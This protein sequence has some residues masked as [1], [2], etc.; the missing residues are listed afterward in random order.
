[1]W[2]RDW[3]LEEYYAPYMLRNPLQSGNDSGRRSGPHKE[4]RIDVIQTTIKALGTSE[5]AMRHLNVRRQSGRIGVA[6][7]GADLLIGGRQLRDNL[8]ANISGGA[9]NEGT[10][11]AGHPNPR[12]SWLYSRRYWVDYPGR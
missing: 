11:H 5:I 1:M 7:Q 10:A 12:A 3:R 9:N 6:S 4:H 8:A 2:R